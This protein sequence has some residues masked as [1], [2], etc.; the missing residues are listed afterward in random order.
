MRAVDGIVRFDGKT[1]GVAVK[2]S[3][4]LAVGI[5]LAS[6]P[7]LSQGA[8]GS[9]GVPM[10]PQ[11]RVAP[12]PQAP[13][14]LQAPVVAPQMP[15]VMPP[16]SV[17]Q[18]GTTSQPQKT[19]RVINNSETEPAT[20]EAQF[21]KTAKGTAGAGPS[22]SVNSGSNRDHIDQDAQ[23]DIKKGLTTSSGNPTNGH[24]SPQ[25]TTVGSTPTNGIGGMGGGR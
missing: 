9:G 11:P 8:M 19:L 2:V 22:Q 7:A 16:P 12:A 14:A 1:P 20:V 4:L 21:S 10:A 17:T 6:P 18:S 13:A 5:A 25:R 24:G 15:L 23:T 3:T